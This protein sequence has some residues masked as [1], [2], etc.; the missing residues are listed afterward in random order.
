VPS[1]GNGGVSGEGGSGGFDGNSGG[2]GGGWFS[3]GACPAKFMCGNGRTG[4]F[5]GG[6]GPDSNYYEVCLTCCGAF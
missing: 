3:N 2:A 5:T 4:G 1:G 6:F